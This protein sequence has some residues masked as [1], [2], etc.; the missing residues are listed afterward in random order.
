MFKRIGIVTIILTV[1]LS[2]FAANNE[3][4][5]LPAFTTNNITAQA[6]WTRITKEDDFH[7]YNYWPDHVGLQPGRAPH[8]P[9][10]K[11][12]INGVIKDD[13]PVTNKIVPIGGMIVKEGYDLDKELVNISVMIKVKDF[14]P[15]ESD[16]FWAQYTPEG[17]VLSSGKVSVCISCHGAFKDNNCIIAHKLGK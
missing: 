9:Y 8:G 2:A 16:W 10:N 15:T 4:K 12:F 13:L 7:K 17:K 14:N 1:Y 3:K 11:V 6:L 5:D